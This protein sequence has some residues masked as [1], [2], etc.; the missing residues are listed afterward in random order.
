[1]QRISEGLLGVVPIN[2]KTMH[3]SHDKASGPSSLHLFSA[4]VCGQVG[5]DEKPSYTQGPHR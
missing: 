5:V 1:M 2:A 3:R 4:W